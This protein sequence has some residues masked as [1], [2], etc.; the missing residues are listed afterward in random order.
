MIWFVVMQVFSTIL[1]WLSLGRKVDQDFEILLL[2]RQLAILKRKLDKALRVSRAEKLPLVV[3][4]TQLKSTANRTT[5]QLRA[6]IR[7]FQPE[8]VF[9]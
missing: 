5:R 1:E 7:I 9:K 2:R 8:T 6:T 4:T 3:L